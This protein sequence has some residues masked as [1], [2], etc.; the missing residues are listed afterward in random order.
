MVKEIELAKHGEAKEVAD[1]LENNE[2]ITNDEL[3]NALINALHRIQYLE[4]VVAIYEKNK[5]K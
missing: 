2:N 5:N 4:K 3:S 1:Y